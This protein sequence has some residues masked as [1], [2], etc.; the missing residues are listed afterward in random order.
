MRLVLR[1]I[2]LTL[3]TAWLAGCQDRTAAPGP[4][5]RPAAAA[6]VPAGA[7]DDQPAALMAQV[8]PGWTATPAFAASVPA[9]QGGAQEGLLVSPLMA[10]PLDAEHRALVVVGQPDDGSGQPQ[11]FNATQVNVGVYGFE[12]RDGRWVRTFSKPSLAWTGANGQVGQAKAHQLGGGR[13]A[14]TFQSGLC[15]QDV[16]SEWVRVFSLDADGTRA[17]T[18]D[19]KIAHKLEDAP[20]CA[21][22]LAGD[23]PADAGKDDP[24]T[25]DNCVDVTGSWHFETTG[26]DGWPDLVVDFKGRRP[27]ADASGT[28]AP[29]TVDGAWRLRHDG[30]GYRAASGRNPLD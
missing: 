15:A 30:S 26:A 18:P 1:L 10:V 3:T 24:V 21:R 7:T 4:D 11:Q 28:L 25:P 20:G 23:P 22:W 2:S 12:R 5:T 19:L 13:V 14:L 16:C 8:F 29:K 9:A 27:V 6:S 17:L